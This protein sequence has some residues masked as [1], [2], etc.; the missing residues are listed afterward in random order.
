MNFRHLTQPCRIGSLEIKNRMAVTAMGVNLAEA[1]GSCGDKIIAFH[2]R[3]AKGGAGLMI[4]GVPGVAW[5]DGG[6]QPR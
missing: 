5:P 4:L 6:N 2:E 1:D 3:Q